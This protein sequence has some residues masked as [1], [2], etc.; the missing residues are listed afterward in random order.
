MMTKR[1]LN[2]AG[3]DAIRAEL[4]STGAWVV[5]NAVEL[6]GTDG[7]AVE[8][9]AF[10][11][12]VAFVEFIETDGGEVKFTGTAVVN[13]AGVEVLGGSGVEDEFGV[14]LDGG[15]VMIGST[16]HVESPYRSMR[17]SAIWTEHS[18]TY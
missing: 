12:L 18:Q 2:T 16:G 14:A 17:F 9:V 6:I 10:I 8:L 1:Y 13:G 3:T 7:A 4:A 5:G 11:A 15:R